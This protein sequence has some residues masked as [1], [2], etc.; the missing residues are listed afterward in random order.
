MPPPLDQGQSSQRYSLVNTLNLDDMDHFM[1]A[2]I[3]LRPKF[4]MVHPNPLK[5]ANDLV[6]PWI[7]AEE[8]ALCR[9]WIHVS[10]TSIEGNAKKAAEFWMKVLTYFKKEMKES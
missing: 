2:N 9:A 1:V 10:E 8:V 7:H 4:R 5:P 6:E 3:F